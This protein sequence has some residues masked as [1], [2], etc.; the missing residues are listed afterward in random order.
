MEHASSAKYSQM[1]IVKISRI[2]VRTNLM[3]YVSYFATRAPSITS[4]V[5]FF[6]ADTTNPR[7]FYWCSKGVGQHGKCPDGEFFF[8]DEQACG[9]DETTLRPGPPAPP[10]RPPPTT[11]FPNHPT[12]PPNPCLNKPDDVS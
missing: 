10:T 12:L 1:V 8:E 9:Y 4:F 5:Q 7:A 3:G 6:V 2:R 11:R